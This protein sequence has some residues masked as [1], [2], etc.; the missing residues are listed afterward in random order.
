MEYFFKHVSIWRTDILRVT[1]IFL[2]NFVVVI[3]FVLW[4]HFYGENN[5]TSAC[6]LKQVLCCLQETAEDNNSFIGI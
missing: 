3:W 2:D 4:K 6:D 1:I 5:M